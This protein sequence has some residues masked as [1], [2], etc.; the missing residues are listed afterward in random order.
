MKNY[1]LNLV[2]TVTLGVVISI[3]LSFLIPGW[4]RADWLA[5]VN[6]SVTI[7]LVAVTRWAYIPQGEL[8]RRQLEKLKQDEEENKRSKVEAYLYGSNNFI[9]VENIGKMAAKNVHVDIDGDGHMRLVTA[10]GV[11]RTTLDPGERFKVG[12]ILF[13]RGSSHKVR[14]KLHWEES[15][16]APRDWDKVL[17]P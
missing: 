2:L 4:T 15:D 6:V 3:G 1:W 7:W 11:D 14:V 9:Y 5:M 13:A 8:A 16:G 12:G 17:S 10:Q